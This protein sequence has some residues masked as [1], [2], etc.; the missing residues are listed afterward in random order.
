MSE[1]IQILFGIKKSPKMASGGDKDYSEEID[2]WTEDELKELGLTRAE[3]KKRVE[4]AMKLAALIKQKEE[5]EIDSASEPETEP[6]ETFQDRCRGLAALSRKFATKCGEANTY[7]DTEQYTTEEGEIVALSHAAKL[8]ADCEESYQELEEKRLWCEQLLSDEEL[9]KRANY[10]APKIAALNIVRRLHGTRLDY[11]KQQIQ[12]DRI[13]TEDLT[14]GASGE[15]LGA[16][17]N[18]VTAVMGSNFVLKDHVSSRFDGNITEYPGW[19][20]QIMVGIEEMKKLQKPQSM[21]LM[22]VKNCLTGS[23]LQQVKSLPNTADNLDLAME[24]LEKLF[25]DRQIFLAHIMENIF[26]ID[27]MKDNTKSLL[28]GLADINSVYSQLSAIEMEPDEF[29]LRIF[30]ASVQGKLSS[31]A[32]RQWNKTL[33]EKFDNSSKTGSQPLEFSDFTL[34]IDKALKNCQRGDVRP[35]DNKHQNQYQNQNRNRPN[36]PANFSTRTAGINCP[37]C[38]QKNATHY[39]S[40]CPDVFKMPRQNVMD[41]QKRYKLCMQCFLPGHMSNSKDCYFVNSSCK[42]MDSQGA[43]CG[44]SHHPSLCKN[45]YETSGFS[46]DTKLFQNDGRGRGRGRGSFGPGGR[47][48]GTGPPPGNPFSRK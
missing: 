43:V 5:G 32:S 44:N 30:V 8:L 29:A 37:F 17:A 31:F 18:T 26:K 15:A 1:A 6:V 42:K 14:G 13:V 36:L 22:E 4:Q 23:A 20:E 41:I 10:L 12:Q 9:A 34:C 24:I 16:L 19:K 28:S 25:G 33:N 48:R 11:E 3:A 7:L 45:R 39:P 46:H 40:K 2:K 47:G 35:D 38:N 27:K 21:I